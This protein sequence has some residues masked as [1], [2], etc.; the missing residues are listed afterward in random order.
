[1]LNYLLSKYQ[2]LTLA[3]LAGLITGSL[4]KIWPWKEV[5]ETQIIRGKEYVIW[6]HPI[7]PAAID[8]KFFMAVFMALLGFGAV[9]VIER[10]SRG[11]G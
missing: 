6:G 9:W 10:L 4:Q 5:I 11:R 7:L 8:Q 1:V 3:F 2:N